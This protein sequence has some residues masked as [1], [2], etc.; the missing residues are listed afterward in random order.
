MQQEYEGEGIMPRSL[1][2]SALLT[3]GLAISLFPFFEICKHAPALSLVNA[4]AEDPYDAVGSFG[5]QLAPF[6]S[7]LAVLRA[8]RPYQSEKTRDRQQ[9]LFARAAYFSCVSV[10]VT[11]GADMIAM[12][13][14]PSLWL[15]VSAG[16]LLAALLG[17]MVLLTAL[18]LWSISRVTRPLP[19]RSPLQR[20]TKA[21]AFSLAGLLI[22]ALYPEELRQSIA[23][24][25]LTI[26][27]GAI[28]LFGLV[29]AL[30]TAIA[31]SLDTPFE[32]VIDDLV[33]AYQWEKAHTGPS[34]PSL[35]LDSVLEKLLTLSLV[36]SV[37]RWLTPRKHPWRIALLLGVFMGI[38]LLLSAMNGEGGPPQLGRWAM[39]AAVFISAECG[40]VLLGY[41]LFAKPLGLFRPDSRP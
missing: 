2:V 28:F 31:P 37:L 33:A 40:G 4:F 10:A 38:A 7:L 35:A 17:G 39:V 26:A 29:W 24:E 11:L 14:H 22:L 19:L 9:V 30:G 16:Y 8:F 13:R 34:D 5:I 21:S 15:G 32:D 27:V 41:A 25:L 23:G 20:W 12:I 6:L 36:R 1:K 18:V 3:F